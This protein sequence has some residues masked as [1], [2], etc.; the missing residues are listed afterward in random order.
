MT[1]GDGVPVEY[2]WGQQLDQTLGTTSNNFAIGG[3]GVEDAAIMF[4]ATSR[5]VRMKRAVFFF[6]DFYRKTVCIHPEGSMKD[7][8][9]F[10]LYTNV[11]LTT[12]NEF[13]HK[14][15]VDI[16]REAYDAQ[17]RLNV[18]QLMDT[19]RSHIQTILYVA[20]LRGIEVVLG[21]WNDPVAQV[22][23]SMGQQDSTLKIA[24]WSPMIDEGR[25]G[26]HPGILTHARWAE[27][28]AK[29]I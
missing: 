4:L 20:Q 10:G 22:L 23:R 26:H 3:S 16:A 14:D 1:H 21:T 13:L 18:L 8:K 6:P 17:Y 9:Y 24:Q 19:C 5:L 11:N 2:R 7:S 15:C 25:D 28:F 29:V 12:G 27:E